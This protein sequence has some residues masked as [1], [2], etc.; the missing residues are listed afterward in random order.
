MIHAPG[1]E[2]QQVSDQPLNLDLSAAWLRKARG[3]IKPFM[4]ALAQRLADALPGRVEVE[5][6]RNGFFSS[7]SHVGR[8][9]VRLDPDVFILEEDHG[10]LQAR[11]TK[12]VRNVSLRSDPMDVP[13]WLQAVTNGVGQ[14]AGDAEAARTALHDILLS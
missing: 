9:T 4:A 1:Q 6:R 14:M 8:I 10:V 2:N 11:R 5:R 3:D 12:L 13:A 7:A